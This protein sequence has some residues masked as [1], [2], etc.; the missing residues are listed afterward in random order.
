M[1]TCALDNERSWNGW[2][3]DPLATGVAYLQCLYTRLLPQD[4][5]AL[6]P[7]DVRNN[8]PHQHQNPHL[9]TRG[10]W[11]R[12]SSERRQISPPYSV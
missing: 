10:K 5:E 11:E 7:S 8:Y 2:G 1:K 9:K 6:G 12:G 4:R 3:I